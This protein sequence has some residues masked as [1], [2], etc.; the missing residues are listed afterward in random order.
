MI[1]YTNTGIFESTGMI[2][3]MRATRDREHFAIFIN[4]RVIAAFDEKMKA[5]KGIESI[6]RA[7]AKNP[8]AIHIYVDEDEEF[9]AAESIQEDG[10]Y[11]NNSITR[12]GLIE[13][14]LN[15][16]DEDIINV[17]KRAGIL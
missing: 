8:A 15:P 10:L 7:M 1:I 14:D 3:D 6:A 16:E 9:V 2:I 4:E 11:E 12:D 17:S 5:I 13:I